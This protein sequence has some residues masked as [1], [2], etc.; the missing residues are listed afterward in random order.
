MSA[1]YA[2]LLSPR[3]FDATTFPNAERHRGMVIARSVPF[4]ALCAHHLL[5]FLGTATVGYLPGEQLLGLS[6]LARCVELFASRLQVQED[7]T[8]QIAGWLQAT[9]PDAGGVGVIVGAEHLCMS[10]RGAQVRGASTVTTA[11]RG[12]LAEETAAR[13]EFLSLA[14][15]RPGSVGNDTP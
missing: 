12:R 3:P 5:P 9:L 15:F 13:A 4:A 2:E 10:V 1:S 6:K 14:A 8:E 7:L 11:W